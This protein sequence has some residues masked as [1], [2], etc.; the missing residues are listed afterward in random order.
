[1]R[2][3]LVLVPLTAASL[4]LAVGCGSSSDETSDTAA[5]T[6]SAAD[7]TAASVE[8]SAAGSEGSAGTDAPATTEAEAVETTALPKP[9]VSI[10]QEIPTELVVTD[11]IEG[12]GPAAAEGDTVLVHY[13]GVR[14]E[15]GTE[16]DNSYDSGRPFSVNLGAGGVI[17]G[18]DQGLVG[19]KQGGRRQLD[20]PAELAYGDQPQ[21]DVI[22]AGDALTFLRPMTWNARA[23][24]W[25]PPR[26]CMASCPPAA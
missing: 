22:Q 19:V 3:R 9:E 6:E 17:T 1:M 10:P 7:S 12:T 25:P 15:D 20:I 16:F 18:W 21:G 14:S 26:R 24:R 2:S 5:A 8:G 11:L 13:V 4:L 23:A